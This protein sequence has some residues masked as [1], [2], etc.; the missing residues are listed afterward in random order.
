MS[1][2]SY[3]A[4][5]RTYL[6]S[7][8]ATSYALRIGVDDVPQHV[9]WGVPLTLAQASALPV[10]DGLTSSFAS[11]GGEELAVEGGAR[12]GVPSLLV[13]YADGTRGVEWVHEGHE[14]RDDRLRV[15]LRDRHYPLACTLEYA[16]HADSDIIERSLTLRHTDGQGEPVEILRCD[17]A[18]WSVPAASGVRLS[19][20]VG[21]WS[22][23]TQLR[24]AEAP[25][26]ET[27]FTSRRGLSGHY[28]NPWVM[29]DAGDADEE[30][31]AVWSMALAWSGSWR[32]TAHRDHTGGPFT[33][34][35]GA[36]HDGLSWRLRPGETHNTP[37]FAGQFSTRGFGGT[38]RAWHAYIVRHVLPRPDE[39]RPVLYN[40]WEA[41]GWDVTLEGQRALA[42]KAAALGVELF[43]VDDGWFGGRTSDHAGLGDWHPN[44]ERFPQGLGPLVEAVR[45]H[46]MKF[47]LWVEPEMTNPDSELYRAHPDWVLHMPHRR[48]TELRNQLV[49]NFARTD[50]TEWA[51]KWLDQLVSAHAIDFLK[52]D[53]NRALTEASWPGDPDA[54][55]LWSDHV[56]GVY[57]VLD[58]LRQAHPSLRIEGCA[59]GGGRADLGML[60]YTDQTWIS[61]NTDADD[62]ITIQHGY[63]QLYPARTMDAWVTDSPNPF[64]RRTTPLSYRFHVAMTGALGI[65]GDL[66]RWTGP[67]LAEARALLTLYKDI[68]PVVQQGEQYRLPD[69]VQYMSGDR[70]VVVAWGADRSLRLSGLD[71]TAV[72]ADDATGTEYAAA[73]LL[74]H[75]LPLHLPKGDKPSTVVRLTR[76]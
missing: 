50:V 22:G 66:S 41:T 1:Q 7:T 5:S 61:D 6:L 59:G 36:G 17:A 13:R 14:I 27:V 2:V 48:R 15:R 60:R 26:A 68:R 65:G 74:T 42:E 55:R 43:V 72:Y 73:T 57:T 30:H 76:L 45:G 62:R 64:T 71:A 63:S 20:T 31:G 51:Y 3:D 58:R 11:T 70:V 29:V 47:G 8:P 19:H 39:L 23:E 54:E 56:R 16:V 35:G 32:I 10:Y 21:Q 9:H 40:S 33:V 18:A 46:G 24:R 67:E 69:A 75:G 12:F 38:S 52:W 4:S 34:T 53:M 28:A 25:Y 49:L 37:V 44:P